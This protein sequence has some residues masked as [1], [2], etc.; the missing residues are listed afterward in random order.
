[1]ALVHAHRYDEHEHLVAAPSSRLWRVIA[2]AS[3]IVVALAVGYFV[4]RTPLPVSDDADNLL[5]LQRRGLGDLFMAQFRQHGYMRPM[6]WAALKV[7]FDVAH[8]HYFAV[9]KTIH[10]LQLLALG[11]LF[12]RLLQVNSLVSA[13]AV[14]FGAAALFGSHGFAPM[15]LDEFPINHFLTVIVCCMAAANLAFGKPALWR[16]IAGVALFVFAVLTVEKGLLVWVILVAA[17]I[18]GCRGVSNRTVGLMTIALLVYFGL[19]FGVLDAGTPPLL[20]RNTGFGFER[21]EPAEIVRRFGG[22]P[23]LFYAYNVVSQILTVLFGEPKGGVWV[24]ARAISTGELLPR[25]IISVFGSTLATVFIAGYLV[26]RFGDWRRGIVDDRD[27][28][29]FIC[30][31]VLVAN[32]VI[33]YPYARNHI[34]APASVFHALAATIAVSHALAS[35]SG[36]TSIAPKA[37]LLTATM[38]LTS[39]WTLRLAAIEYRMYENA[40]R[41]RNE[42]AYMG[43]TPKRWNLSGDQEGLALV[44]QLYDEAIDRKV[45]GTYFFPRWMDRFFE[46][47]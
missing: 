31:A 2:Y 7:T 20:E 16:D 5:D 44:R 45:A 39:L 13:L 47:Y 34:V 10:L 32:A 21:L 29:V 28:V 8:G 40:F 6:L 3:V 22:N 23:L 33:G 30:A 41:I 19:R 27:R 15:V 43:P 14:A 26:A 38:V 46:D 35:L 4:V 24:L 11:V 9:Y 18:A 42:W 12:V 36:S 1:M 37:A 25:H 17:R